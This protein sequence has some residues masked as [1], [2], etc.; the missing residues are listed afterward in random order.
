MSSLSN[1]IQSGLLNFPGATL[2][3]KTTTERLLK[4]DEESHHCFFSPV[5]F[6]NHLAHQY[7]AP[8]VLY[9]AGGIVYFCFCSLLAA[10]DLG[11]PAQLIQAIYDDEAKIQRPIDLR[12]NGAAPEDVPKP[13]VINDT[14]WTEYLG[15]EK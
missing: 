11:A 3:S 12:T 5:G 9:W 1:K 13:G 2:E 6:H 4:L 8:L 15:N 7:V 14:N 10:Y